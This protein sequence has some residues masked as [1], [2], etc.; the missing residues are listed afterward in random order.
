MVAL[1]D[2]DVGRVLQKLK[3]LHLDDNTL[4]IFS[5]DNGATEPFIAPL[6]SS[7]GLRG[8]K[9]FLYEGGVRAPFIARW[10][11]RIAPGTTSD[12]LTTHVDFLATAAEVVGVPVPAD[13]DGISIL[14]TLLGQEQKTK[15]EF[16]FFEIYEPIFQ[17]AVR[18]ADWKGYRLGTKAPLELYDLG[19]DPQ[20]EHNIATKH[21]EVVSRLELILTREHIPT[22]HWTAPEIPPPVG[23]TGKKGR[24]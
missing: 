5:S 13:G 19:A 22:P 14:P 12:L 16:L 1:L 2:R 15:H 21:P 6:G 18:V 7:G 23:K 8:R 3:D 17:Q 11:G 9:Q 20:E 4:V 24:G 10:P